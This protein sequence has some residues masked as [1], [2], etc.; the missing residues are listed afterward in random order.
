MTWPSMPPPRVKLRHTNRPPN[1]ISMAASRYS[2]FLPSVKG[3]QLDEADAGQAQCQQHRAE[4]PGARG[5]GGVRSLDRVVEILELSRAGIRGCRR[6]STR[7][8]PAAPRRRRRRRSARWAGSVRSGR[9]WPRPGGLNT[10]GRAEAI[11]APN[12][13]EHALHGIAQ[14]ALLRRQLVA[15]EGAERLHRDVER[16]VDHPQRAGGHP[17]R[18]RVGHE[19]QRHGGQDRAAQEVRSATAQAGPGA[20]RV[21]ADDRLHDQSGQWRGDPQD[22]DVLDLCAQG[23]EDAADVGV[24]QRESELDA[25][26]AEAHVPDLPERQFGFAVHVQFPWCD[27]SGAM[28]RPRTSARLS[29]PMAPPWPPV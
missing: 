28:C 17:Q 4:D 5:V 6:P 26:E 23:L 12:A 13:D 19:H 10:Q 27:G 16:G 21:V 7:W 22:R 18:G 24:L 15:D 14:R 2:S 1:T 3:Q 9:Y 11:T 8:R 20:V 25:E 29:G